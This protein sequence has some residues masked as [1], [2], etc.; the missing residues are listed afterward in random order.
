MENNLPAVLSNDRIEEIE[1]LSWEIPFGNTQY[2]IEK[3]LE[4]HTPERQVRM[5][6]LQLNEKIKQM[7]KYQLGIERLKLR[8]EE[9]Q[10]KIDA[11]E[12]R[13]KRLMELDLQE[14]EM[15]YVSNQKLVNDSVV[16]INI[17]DNLLKKAQSK[18][19]VPVTRESFEQAEQT[20]WEK[21]MVEEASAQIAST[22]HIDKE[23]RKTMGRIGLVPV[24]DEKGIAFA[25]TQPVSLLDRD[26]QKQLLEQKK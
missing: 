5:I 8:I 19:H 25:C 2:Q 7:K 26:E 16:E 13:Q 18:I 6:L 1:K 12:G 15:D 21:R 23:T 14:I 24:Q 11:S 9:M 22:G 10:E 3:F 17:Y 4:E 20:Y